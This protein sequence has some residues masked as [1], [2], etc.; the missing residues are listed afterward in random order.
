MDDKNYI[1]N[2]INGDLE[3][4]LDTRFGAVVVFGVWFNISLTRC[5]YGQGDGETQCR[6]GH[7]SF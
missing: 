7:T 1:A 5:G 6:A 3:A 2:N 4:A